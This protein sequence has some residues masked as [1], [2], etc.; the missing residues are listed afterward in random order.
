M[1]DRI[2]VMYRGRIQ[3]EFQS[4]EATQARVLTAALGLAS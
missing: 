4:A 1:S 3:A 2:V